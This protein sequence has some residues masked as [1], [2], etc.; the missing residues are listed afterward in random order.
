MLLVLVEEALDGELNN[1]D[2]QPL[3]AVAEVDVILSIV[4]YLRVFSHI[5][6][7]LS[8]NRHLLRLHDSLLIYRIKFA[9]MTGRPSSLSS[10]VG[11]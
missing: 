5:S 7:D 1:A 2:A 8:F 4:F 11:A 10:I 6:Y 9:L 3:S